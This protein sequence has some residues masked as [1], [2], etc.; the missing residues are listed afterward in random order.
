MSINQVIKILIFCKLNTIWLLVNAQS[1]GFTT[2]DCKGFYLNG[3]AY[4]PLVINYTID[5]ANVDPSCSS[6]YVSPNWGYSYANSSWANPPT[7]GMPCVNPMNWSGRPSYEGV[8]PEQ[9]TAEMKLST[10]FLKIKQMGFNTIRIF[11]SREYSPNMGGFYNRA[12]SIA[13]DFSVIDA[14]LLAVRKHNSDNND[15]L[16]VIFDAR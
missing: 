2:V 7:N 8:G 1:T 4:R 15:N 9:T 11:S 16:K 10:D 12:G 3:L 6:Y 13:N 5:Y 14:F